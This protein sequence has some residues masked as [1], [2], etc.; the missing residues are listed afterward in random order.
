M[1]MAASMPGGFPAGNDAFEQLP[2][3]QRGELLRRTDKAVTIAGR[4]HGHE[5]VA[6]QLISLDGRWARRFAHEVA[7]YQVFAAAPPP[8]RVPRLHHAGS[9]VLI[10]ERLPGV[11]PHTD[12][13]PPRLPEMAVAGMIDVLAVFARW[14]PPHGAL[15]AQATDWGAR[16]GRYVAA[17][18]LAAEDQ[19]LLLKAVADAPAVFGHGD[20]LASNAL[21]GDHGPLMFIDY[22]FAGLYPQGADLA[23]VGLWLGRHDPDTEKRCSQT[24]E[25]AGYLLSYQAMRVLWIAR[26]RRLYQT[27]FDTVDD[28]DHRQWLADQAAAASSALRRAAR[29]A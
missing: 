10:I 4:W 29:P 9:A 24:A 12:R 20:P 7:A 27:L 6:K 28:R 25:A 17:G 5:V 2:G 23:L 3:L 11:P 21:C 19:P 1:Q 22:E 18:D 16:I 14:E 15:Y 26:E 13:Y 8:W